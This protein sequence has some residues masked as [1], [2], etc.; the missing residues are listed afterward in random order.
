VYK[1]HYF[2][3][4]VLAGGSGKRIKTEVAKQFIQLYG[5]PMLYYSL[6]AF[7][8][9]P[10]DSIVLVVQEQDLEYCQKEIVEK[11][12]IPKISSIVSGGKR[13]YHS[14]ISG[15][16]A[17][18]L[19]S[20]YLLIHD[21]ARPCITKELI[22]SCMDNVIEYGNGT[23]GVRAVDTICQV[24]EENKIVSIPNRNYLW[25]IQT[26]QCFRV[27][28]IKKAH[29]ALMEKEPEMSEAEK[30]TITDDVAVIQKFLG[31]DVYIFQGSYEN[32][33]VTNR[34]DI[35]RAERLLEIIR[36]KNEMD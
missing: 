21:G 27:E 20:E 31:Q 6:R 22:L 4:I 2:T 16:L 23:T 33:K 32:I 10:V 35:E 12:S 24:D 26:P 13:R 28:D 17:S 25:S 1:G 3:A 18:P 19:A 9:S 30:E 34:S 15:V 11:Y 5:R 29:K 7:S 8:D 36:Y 14:S